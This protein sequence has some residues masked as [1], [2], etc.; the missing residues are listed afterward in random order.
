MINEFNELVKIN[1]QLKEKFNLDLLENVLNDYDSIEKFI[2][3][4]KK[5]IE[6][7]IEELKGIYDNFSIL[8]KKS[9]SFEYDIIYELYKYSEELAK[10]KS[11]DQ[12]C[13]YTGKTS[14]LEG[15]IKWINSDE[16]SISVEELKESLE[17]EIRR[18]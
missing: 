17:D 16:D 18:L 13:S 15:I 7:S 3:V 14:E 2:D 4:S 8:D 1:K 5:K 9:L 6:K 11:L 10:E 12:V